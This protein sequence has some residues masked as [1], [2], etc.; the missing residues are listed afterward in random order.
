MEN[1]IKNSK[2]NYILGIIVV[3]VLLASV[4]SGYI[5][6]HYSEIKYWDEFIYPG[7]TVEGINLSGKTKEQALLIITQA[8]SDKIS[9]NKI[10]IKAEDKKYTLN[11]SK[12]N[13]KCNLNEVVDQAYAYGKN[14]N[15]FSK[16]NKIKSSKPMNYKLK[17]SYDVNGIKSMI[18]KIERDVNKDPINA[19]LE[20]S[21]G[22]FN[23]IPE[24]KGSKLQK[25]KLEKE[26]LSQI[27]SGM[28]DNT[29][30]KISMEVSEPKIKGVMLKEINSRIGGFSTNFGSI[31]SSQRANN[32][33]IATKSI[34]RT[35]V[36]PGE[37]FSFN[38]VVGERTED[39]G[40]EAAPVIVNNKLESG[41]G[42]GI[43]QVSTTLFNAV[44]NAG[45][46]SIERTHHTLPVHYIESGM[47]ATVDFGNIDYKFKNTL[48]YP[49]YIRAYTSGGNVTFNLYSNSTERN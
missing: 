13:L 26:I 34:D 28:L 6:Y 8:Y 40:Y 12:V 14:L 35:V 33:A 3:L 44:N 18:S 36:L 15:L 11:Y 24:Q 22:K 39:K 23:I 21:D 29:E 1:S 31:S 45:L 4:L 25:E 43:C 37:I 20:I 48:K 17:F 30:L 7:V 41:L 27:D 5:T 42:G 49:I 32:I 46:P 38:N 9:N 10:N 16:Y 19:H 2:S 47:D